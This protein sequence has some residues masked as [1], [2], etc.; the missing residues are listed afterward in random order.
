M[1]MPELIPTYAIGAAS[2][3]ATAVNW[4]FNFVIG[5][6]FPPMKEGLGDYSFLPFAIICAVGVAFTFFLVPETKGRN[7]NEMVKQ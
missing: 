2:S 6:T 5:Q 3:T 4:L 7:P 1:L